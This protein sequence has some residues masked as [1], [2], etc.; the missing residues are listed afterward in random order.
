MKNDPCGFARPENAQVDGS[1]EAFMEKR[2]RK[3]RS[4]WVRAG[5][6]ILA[7]LALAAGL[8]WI[9]Q[10]TL[11]P[12]FTDAEVDISQ[13]PTIIERGTTYLHA[14][15]RPALKEEWNLKRLLAIFALQLAILTAVFPLGLGRKGAAYVRRTAASLK[16]VLT[17][18]KKR[19]AKLAVCFAAAFLAVFFLGRVWIWDVYHRA[20]W[21]V[22]SVCAWAGVCA[23]CLVT[24][25]RTLGKKPEIFFLI[26]TLIAGGLFAWYLPDA[27]TVS[28]DDGER[29]QHAANFSMMGRVRFTE[30]DWDAMQTENKKHYRLDTREEF[31]R[32]QDEK[33]AAGAVYVTSGFHLTPKQYWTATYGLG[34]FLGRVFHLRYWDMWSLG[35]LTG[36]AAYA[37]IGYFAIRRLKYGRMTLAMALMLP[38]AVFLA[39]NYS[40]DPGVTAGIAISCAYWIAQWQEPEKTI[41]KKDLAVMILGMMAACYAKAIYFPIFLLFFFL[42]DS[43]FRDARHR[44][45]YRAVIGVSV[46]AVMMYILLPLSESGGQADVRA[47]GNVNTFEQI[48]F[49]LHH[50]LVYAEYLWHFLQ[51]YL[52]PNQMSA[53]VN[54]FGYMGVGNSTTLI[55][56]ILAVTAFTDG[57]EKELRPS[58]WVCWAGQAILFGTLVLMITAMYAWMSEV[59]SPEFGGVQ[60][61]Y[62]IPFFYPAMA[63]LGRNRMKTRE[64]PALYHG[65]LFALM[66]FAAFSGLLKVCVA[67]YF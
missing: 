44:R 33:Y 14:S 26:L 58:G 48:Q 45:A 9:T 10:R 31:L 63:L 36:L 43:K 11:P 60:T 23:G 34:L 4:G 29:F 21:M 16:R 52:D 19:N 67:R 41:G 25:R 61:R 47:L 53:Q 3:I 59:G 20:N 7:A 6:L 64:N 51:N 46:L 50:P 8:E 22:D 30:A 62:L 66:T 1:E 13:D 39:A 35:R 38:S 18:E 49:V 55:L 37:L 2:E 57:Q 27:T 28:L 24:F 42:P 54:A 15:G 32:A 65:I 12:I 5:L 40:Y 56:M 17:R